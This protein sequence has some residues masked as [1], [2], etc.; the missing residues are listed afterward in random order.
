MGKINVLD[1]SIY[2]RIAAGEVVERPASIVKELV[3]NSLDA[4]ATQIRI[5]VLEG[6]IKQIK[7][8]DNGC[9]IEPDDVK[10]AFYPHATSKIYA[11]ED[12][13]EI[14]TLGFRGEALASIASVSQ[15]E[16]TSKV[17]AHE[18][19]SHLKIEGGK[20]L[21]FSE[22][23]SANGTYITVNNL[24]YNVPAR[25]K[26]LKSATREE[27]EV[28]NLVARFILANPTISFTYFANNKEVYR[29]SGKNLEEALFTVYGKNT[30][31]NVIAFE[32]TVGQMK[33]HGYLGKP[34][35]AKSNR[36]YQ[37]LVIN[38]R[39]VV[40]SVVSAA[41]Y[42]AYQDY[43]MKGK[44]PFFVIHMN[45]PLEVLDVNVHPN[46]LDVKFENSQTIYGTIYNT[47]KQALQNA[48]NI[49]KT[50]HFSFAVE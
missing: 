9:G 10:V 45:M 43:L 49:L 15:V 3:E 46:K 38:G 44:F 32:Q 20:E 37:T 41:A 14:G 13:D 2:N 26:F 8:S 17:E 31:E 25:H 34:T 19:G 39:Y 23:A 50:T 6:G 30:L 29:S 40:N 35:F 11:L 47:I 28:T 5:E 1:S 22:A 12:L 16:L 42:A 4:G 27:S 36:T 33:L 24:F 7:V 21:E 48:N 18:T